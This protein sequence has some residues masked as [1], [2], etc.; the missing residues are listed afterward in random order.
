MLNQIKILKELLALKNDQN[1]ADDA[2]I[3]LQNKLE[4]KIII[5]EIELPRMRIA[6]AGDDFDFIHLDAEE[7]ISELISIEFSI[8]IILAKS[9]FTGTPCEFR[10]FPTIRFNSLID[11]HEHGQSIIA[12]FSF[13]EHQ[14]G[15]KH[16]YS[17]FTGMDF[18]DNEYIFY[19]EKDEDFIQIHEQIMENRRE[20]NDLFDQFEQI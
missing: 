4:K 14:P 2:L 12:D 5:S 13:E 8:E 10:T 1:E 19:F 18:M 9:R 3:E 11:N 20:L 16:G 6:N 15:G 7:R 17:A